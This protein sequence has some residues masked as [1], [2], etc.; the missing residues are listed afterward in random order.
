M[1]A[2]LLKGLQTVAVVL[3]SAALFCSKEEDTQ[4]LTVMKL[5]SLVL[6][7]SGT[8][9]FGF[10]GK[11]QVAA[12]VDADDSTTT[13]DNQGLDELLRGGR[14]QATSQD[15]LPRLNCP[16]CGSSSKSPTRSCFP[17]SKARIL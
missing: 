14:A 10:G 8:L 15:T 7:L 12:N 16:D 2:A 3:S 9:L 11:R 17:G 4:C 5:L 1:G 13:K 6:V